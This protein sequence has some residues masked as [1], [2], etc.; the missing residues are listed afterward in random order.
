MEKEKMLA[1]FPHITK[2]GTLIDVSDNI[3]YYKIHDFQA[4]FLI[5]EGLLY[6][7]MKH[8]IKKDPMPARFWTC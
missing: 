5:K 3:I 8:Q 1:L 6:F 4:V 7:H 2:T